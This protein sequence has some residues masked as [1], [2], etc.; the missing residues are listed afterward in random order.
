MTTGA[1]G[2]MKF[3]TCLRRLAPHYY[4]GHHQAFVNNF[5]GMPDIK[6]PS[7]LVYARGIWVEPGNN[8]V[9]VQ[10]DD[11]D[12]FHDAKEGQ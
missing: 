1:L 7:A 9:P 6:V 5:R 8:E 2:C 3:M 10:Q 12:T 11:L 4:S